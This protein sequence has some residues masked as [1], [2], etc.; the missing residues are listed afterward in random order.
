M[1]H[2]LVPRMIRVAIR[3]PWTE[4]CAFLAEPSNLNHWASGLG[5]SLHQEQGGWRA[6][7]PSGPVS[8]RFSPPNAEGIADHWVTVAPGVVVTVPLRAV[9][10]PDGTEVQLTLLPQPGM[11]A[12]QFEADAD[13]MQRDLAA[14]KQLLEA[15]Q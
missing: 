7:G 14:L 2:V 12:G 3:R 11:S 10:A 6:A 1:S 5:H 4:V 13:W 9:P 15:E 8:I